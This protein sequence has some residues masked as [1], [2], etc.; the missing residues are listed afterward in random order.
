MTA[1]VV[2]HHHPQGRVAGH[3]AALVEALPGPVAFVSTNLTAEGAA[4]LPSRAKV[5]TRPNEGYDFLSY[6]VG[7]ERLGP[8]FE[9]AGGIVILNSSF[10][11]LDPAKLLDAFFARFDAS[12]HLVGLTRSAE[13]SPHL[14]SYWVGFGREAVRAPA[15]ARWWGQVAPLAG[16]GHVVGSYELGMSSFF[17]ASG[18][19][20][21]SVFEAPDARPVNP[22]NAFAPEILERLGIVKIEFLRANPLGLD[23]KAFA[24]RLSPRE[25]ALVEDA[26]A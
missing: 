17:A 1:W 3:L 2:A 19:R 25:R 24:A 23:M 5:W 12:S 4:R 14:Q 9:D 26:L 7:L 8:A 6:R 11:A 18:L 15:F 10:V 20:L 16:R 22:M 13:F 21:E